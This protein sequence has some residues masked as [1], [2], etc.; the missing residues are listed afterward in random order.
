MKFHDYVK[1]IASQLE[2]AYDKNDTA[3]YFRLTRLLIITARE[4]VLEKFNERENSNSQMRMP[5]KS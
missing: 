1:L 3:E 4:D 5:N 2:K